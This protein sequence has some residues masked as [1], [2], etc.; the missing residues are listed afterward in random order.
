MIK[1]IETNLSMEGD[2]IKDHQSRVI[3]TDSWEGFIDEIKTHK[4]V[5]RTAILG[6]LYGNTVPRSSKVENLIYDDKHLSCDVYNYANMK[7]RKLAY[8]INEEV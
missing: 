2:I 7:T 3:E 8:L 6:S 4:F 5:M 1:I